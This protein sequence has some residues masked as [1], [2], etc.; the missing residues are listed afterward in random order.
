MGLYSQTIFPLLCDFGLNRSFMAKHRR[1]LL[2]GASGRIL[3]IGFGTGLNVPHYPPD[4]RKLTAVDPNVGMHRRAEKRVR[5]RGIEVDRRIVG[6]ER[7]PFED[8]SFD[9]VVSTFTLCSI[10]QVADALREVHRVLNVGGQFLVSGT[11]RQPGTAGAKVA[12]PPQLAAKTHGRW[13]S[14]GSGHPSV[15]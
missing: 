5:Q 2:A 8:G 7:L 9:C 11:R 4:V 3:E 1:G 10:N 14:P 12:T 13:L 15:S 6:G